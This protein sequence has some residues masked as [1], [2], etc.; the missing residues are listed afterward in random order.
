MYQYFMLFIVQENA[1]SILFILVLVCEIC[2]QSKL[3]SMIL[4]Q[5]T[6][7]ETGELANYDICFPTFVPQNVI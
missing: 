5:R 2:I 7:T 6:L 3:D 4:L 1:F